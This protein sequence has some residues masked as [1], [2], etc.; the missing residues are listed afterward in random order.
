MHILPKL[1]ENQNSY[2]IIFETLQVR[3]ESCWAV[4]VCHVDE[5]T[6]AHLRQDHPP[7]VQNNQPNIYLWTKQVVGLLGSSHNNWDHFSSPDHIEEL[8]CDVIG[9]VMVLK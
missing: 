6:L 8:L 2:R 5:G 4:K 3:S 1:S 9:A 7:I